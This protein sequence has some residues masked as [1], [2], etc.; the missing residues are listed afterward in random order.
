M[1]ER[2]LITLFQN[3]T[4]QHNATPYFKHGAQ[5][6]TFAPQADIQFP[7]VFVQSTGATAGDR[8]ITY[9]FTVY[10]LV[11]PLPSPELDD[12]GYEWDTT[13]VDARDTALQILKDIV[14][15][16]RL[17][18]QQEFTLT[19]AG[20]TSDGDRLISDYNAVGWRTDITIEMDF[21]QDNANFPE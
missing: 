16:V 15:R 19:H 17:T 11:I 9:N 10:A 4:R 3:A 12:T 2:D 6:F 5:D 20:W 21:V 13:A 1:D 18:N 8:R 14:G 7:M